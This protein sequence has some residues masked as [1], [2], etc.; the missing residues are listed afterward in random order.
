MLSD[1][2]V[3]LKLLPYLEDFSCD[4]LS[5]FLISSCDSLSYI[6]LGLCGG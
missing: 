1:V 6:S 3:K 5:F 4:S 2:L